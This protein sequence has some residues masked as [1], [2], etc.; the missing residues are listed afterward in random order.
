M[1]KAN[2]NWMKGRVGEANPSWKGGCIDRNGYRKVGWKGVYLHRIVMEQMLGRRLLPGENVH[3][4]NGNRDDNRPENL[5]LWIS[6]QPT[7]QR[8]EDI[9]KD[10]TEKLSLYAPERL[11][12]EWLK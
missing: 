8:V 4:K 9:V 10:A 7:G 1:A 11:K 12:Q 2:F 5:E 3:H 6:R